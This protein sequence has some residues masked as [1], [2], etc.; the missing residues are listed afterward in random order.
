MVSDSKAQWVAELIYEGL[1]N[2]NRLRVPDVP[3]QRLAERVDVN[4]GS[5]R[6]FLECNIPVSDTGI[7]SRGPECFGAPTFWCS[8][9]H[10]MEADI[11]LQV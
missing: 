7:A 9:R 10:Q 1:H 3:D 4:L 8:E 2:N 5:L 6:T 11:S